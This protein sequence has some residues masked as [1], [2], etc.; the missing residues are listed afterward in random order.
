MDDTATSTNLGETTIDVALAERGYHVVIGEDLLASAAGRLKALLPGA[1]FAVVSDSNVAPLHMG[2]LKESLEQD[3]LFLGSAVVA[4]GEA[5][6][7]FPVL[8]KLCETLLDLG[9]ERGDCVIA[10]DSDVSL[11]MMPLKN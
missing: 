1:R 4:P 8:A 9:V 3:G 5:S 10:L 11:G 2:P 6:K 7:S